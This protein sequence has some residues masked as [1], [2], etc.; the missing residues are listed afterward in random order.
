VAVA[1]DLDR[2]TDSQWDRVAEQAR[3]YLASGG[4]EDTKQ[5]ACARSCSS[6][7]DVPAGSRAAPA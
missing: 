2:A 6:Q 4:T 1:D 5:T 3:T 7:L